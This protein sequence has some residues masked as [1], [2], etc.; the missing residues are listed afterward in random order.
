MC[1]IKQTWGK[2]MRQPEEKRTIHLM[3]PKKEHH[4]PKVEAAMGHTTCKY[5]GT[6]I[7]HHFLHVGFQAFLQNSNSSISLV[8]YL[9]WDD[10]ISLIL[11][12][13]SEVRYAKYFFGG[14]LLEN[15]RRRPRT[16]AWNCRPHKTSM[17]WTLL[18][19]WILMICSER[20]KIAWPNPSYRALH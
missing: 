13:E 5:G 9:C 19:W 18:P 6:S 3:K 14:L 1:N 15:C 11:S 10:D 8:T 7:S 17:K 16:M 20:W 12:V 2:L 4:Q